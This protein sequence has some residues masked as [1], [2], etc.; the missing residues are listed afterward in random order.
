MSNGP[1]LLRSTLRL[2]LLALPFAPADAQWTQFGGPTRDFHCPAGELATSWPEGGPPVLWR[3]PL[4]D[5]YSGVLVDG[6]RL[7]TLYRRDGREVVTCLARSDGA[8]LWEHGY[9]VE[10]TTSAQEFGD[11]PSATAVIAG[12]RL[13]SVGVGIDVHCFDKATGAVLWTL[14]IMEEF[15]IPMPGRGYAPSPLVYEG[16]VILTPGGTNP[17]NA[18][19]DTPNLGLPG[20][21]VIALDVASGDIVWAS[22]DFPGSKASPI[23]IEFGGRTHLVVFM[24]NEL[25]GLDPEYGDLLW[26]V[27]HATDYGFNCSTPVF[28]GVDTLFCSSAYNRSAEAITLI[29]TDGGFEATRKWAS[30]RLC[31]HFTN[32][33]L[34][35]GRLYGV[36]GMARPGL[37]TSVDAETGDMVWRS[38]EFSKANLLYADGAFLILDEDGRLALATFTDDGLEL[39]GEVEVADSYA[40]SAPTLVGTE[41]FVRDRH[42]LTA[43]DLS[44][45]AKTDAPRIE[46]GAPPLPVDVEALVGAYAATESDAHARIALI[47]GWL[48]VAFDADEPVRLEWQ[49]E[50]KLWE[51]VQDRTSGSTPREIT[52]RRA[53]KGPAPGLALRAY[54]QGPAGYERTP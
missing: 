4:G 8:T 34:V 50:R 22:Q 26:R 42:H 17:S 19:D 12:E 40:F 46:L 27:E 31:I 44:S 45:S 11:G 43:F 49:P 33:L 47:D 35:D 37:L 15:E 53:L 23:L 25:A 3:R 16:L 10:T 51:V 41:L 32:M 5:G 24:G 30:R 20:G 7:Y 29:A 2:L 9:P 6:E 48:T 54:G 38:R 52:F 39:R 1:I 14:D 21:A 13:I 28:D 36:S 18:I